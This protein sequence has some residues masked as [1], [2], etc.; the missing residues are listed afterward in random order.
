[1]P[2]TYLIL[3][4]MIDVI[5]ARDIPDTRYSDMMIGVTDIRDIPDTR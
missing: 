1:M 3:D 5:D 2:E 4:M